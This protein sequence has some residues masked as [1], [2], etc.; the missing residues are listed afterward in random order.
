MS[1]RLVIE[2]FLSIQNLDITVPTGVTL[3]DGWNEDDQ[4]PE[5]SGKS[6]ILNAKCWCLYGKIPKDANIDDV[7]KTGEKSCVVENHFGN[8]VVRRSRGPNELSLTVDGKVIKGKDARETQAII[9]EYIG[10]TFETFCQTVYFAQNYAKKFITA[11]QEE[12]GKILSE[13]QN[14]SVFDK[15]G[16]EVSELIKI[17][18]ADLIKLKHSKE[19]AVKY[20]DLIKRDIAAEE[21]KRSHALQQQEQRIQNLVSQIAGQEALHKSA[22]DEQVRRISDLNVQVQDAERIASEHESAKEQLL[23]A[24]ADWVYDEPREKQL[25]ELNNQLMGEAGAINAELSG[26]DRLVSKRMTAESQGRRYATR[27]KQ[28][29]VDRQKNLDF[30]ANP[31]KDCPTCG[32]KLESCDTSHAVTE[33]AK[34]DQETAEIT[35]ALTELAA[36]IDAPIPTKDEL[37]AKLADIRQRRN[38]HDEEIKNVRVV[39]DKLNQYA[40]HLNGLDQNVKS[41]RDRIAKLQTSIEMAGRPLVVDTSALDALRMRLESESQPLK[42]DLGPIEALQAK[43]DANQEQVFT[44]GQ[45]IETKTK[46]L[47]RL[48]DLKTGFKEVKSFVFNSLLNQVN[49]RIQK[50]LGQLF[51]VP[52]VVRFVNEDMKIETKVKFDGIDR[53]LGL[54]SGGQFRR[55]SLAVDLALSDVITSRKGSKVNLLILD[56]YFKDLSET[57]MEKCLALLEKRDQPV[58]LIEHNSIFNSIVNQKIHVRLIDGTSSISH[59]VRI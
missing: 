34:L 42:F 50:Y 17:N 12:K 58:L 59:A 54:L 57:S 5:G 55:V 2:N 37:N 36:E 18:E 22:Y 39:K 11:N 14:L 28:V 49:A 4:T 15:A 43:L 30:I 56:E 1:E 7:I 27:Y 32:S 19:V 44:F 41:Q 20:E 47:S 29:Q 24:S 35:A 45:M 33:I 46:H 52:V 25:Q 51:E 9:E 10:L 23:A 6:A 8:A 21:L 3:I 48:E 31:T 16:K 13:V 26:I 40:V 38:A 53:G